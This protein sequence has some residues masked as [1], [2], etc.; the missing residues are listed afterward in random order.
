LVAKCHCKLYSYSTRGHCLVCLSDIC[1][2]PTTGHVW[3]VTGSPQFLSGAAVYTMLQ[4]LF[5]Q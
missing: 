2:R 5:F 4:K 1:Y 3:P